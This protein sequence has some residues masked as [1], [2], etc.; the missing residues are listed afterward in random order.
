MNFNVGTHYYNLSL[1]ESDVDQPRI[2][3]KMQAQGKQNSKP[4]E[5]HKDNNKNSTHSRQMV[6]EILEL[7]QVD[8]GIPEGCGLPFPDACYPFFID[9]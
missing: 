3:R 7:L 1:W 5:S 9:I 4:Q 6:L 2:E 8:S